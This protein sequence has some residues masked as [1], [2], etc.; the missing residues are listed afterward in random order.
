MGM[1]T[2][3]HMNVTLRNDTSESVIR[4]LKTMLGQEEHRATPNH[5]LFQTGRWEY[6]LRCSSYYHNNW[7]ASELTHD[8][9]AK[10][11]FLRVQCDFKNYDNEISK[12]ID[13]ISPYLEAESGEFLGYYRYEEDE[14]PTIIYKKED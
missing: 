7:V 12:F 1:Y 9:H 11:Y 5:P 10:C 3:L 6:M 14:H 2:A 8:V 13:W 4:T